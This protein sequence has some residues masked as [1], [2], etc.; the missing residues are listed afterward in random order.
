MCN[1]VAM[2]I[3]TQFYENIAIWIVAMLVTSKVVVNLIVY[4]QHVNTFSILTA[5]MTYKDRLMKIIDWSIN[6]PMKRD[7][8]FYENRSLVLT[9]V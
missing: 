7:Q 3:Y 6:H 9:C 1:K 4:I 8:Y 5:I 2:L